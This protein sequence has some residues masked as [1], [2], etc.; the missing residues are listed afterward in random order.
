MARAMQMVK[1]VMRTVDTGDATILTSPNGTHFFLDIDNT[2]ILSTVS[3]IVYSETLVIGAG[4]VS[5]GTPISLPNSGSYLGKELEIKL[6]DVV[7]QVGSEYQFEGTGVKTQISFLF[8][9]VETDS[10]DF[11]KIV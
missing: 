8:D 9:L 3:G 2:G 1:G 10:I 6:N 5:T 7:M 4:G 11:T